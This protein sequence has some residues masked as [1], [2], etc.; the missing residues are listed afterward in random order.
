MPGADF[1]RVPRILR[2]PQFTSKTNNV[3]LINTSAAA[4]LS[5]R[6]S[7]LGTLQHMIIVALISSFLSE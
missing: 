5:E 6:F 3:T 2:S 1:N 4:N 7:T